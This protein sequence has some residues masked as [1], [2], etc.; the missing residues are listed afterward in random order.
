MGLTG[1]G[2]D[3]YDPDEELQSTAFRDKLN[4]GLCDKLFKEFRSK[5]NTFW[6]PDRKMYTVVLGAMIMQSGAKISDDNMQHLRELVPKI[7]S[8]PGYALPIFDEGFRDPGRAQ[9]LAALEY[10]KPGTPRTF[11]ELRLA[12]SSLNYMS[13]KTRQDH[14]ILIAAD[15]LLP[16]WQDRGRPRSGSLSLRE[17]QG[18]FV[19]W[20][21]ENSRLAWM[22]TEAK[23]RR[24]GLPEGSLEGP[25][26]FLLRP[27]EPSHDAQRLDRRGPCDRGDDTV[28]NRT[29]TEKCAEV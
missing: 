10:Y 26:A 28:R 23:A 16:L 4:A 13:T 9:F 8:S 19:L 15:Q 29:M 18:G 17:M 20:P 3:D 2:D 1:N 5:E 6:I 11:Y 25:Q 27:Q 12:P 21:G 24:I 22:G 7:H 14:G